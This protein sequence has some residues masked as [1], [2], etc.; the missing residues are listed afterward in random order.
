MEERE[1]IVVFRDYESVID[2]NVAKTKLD[3]YG[4]P[5]FLTQ[6]NM[7]TLMAHNALL[8]AVKLHVFQNDIPRVKE[9]LDEEHDKE[10]STYPSPLRVHRN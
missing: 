4:I 5:C 7:N 6:E 3:A 9:I 1:K 2:A 8:F 10:K